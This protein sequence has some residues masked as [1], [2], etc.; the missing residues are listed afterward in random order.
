MGPLLRV[1]LQPWNPMT[2]SRDRLLIRGSASM[3]N[4]PS[5]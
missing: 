2:A 5:A 3:G 1:G 4:M